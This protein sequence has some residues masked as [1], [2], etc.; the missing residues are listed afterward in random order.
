MGKVP[1]TPCPHI[2]AEGLSS[3][4]GSEFFLV[5]RGNVCEHWSSSLHPPAAPSV[6]QEYI[7]L[8]ACQ[9]ERKT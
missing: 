1:T 9:R 2:L 6:K 4:Q 5:G 3:S 7:Y 8:G